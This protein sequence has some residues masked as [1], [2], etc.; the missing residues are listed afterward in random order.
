MAGCGVSVERPSGVL[1][2]VTVFIADYGRHASLVLPGD[3]VADAAALTDADVRVG[4]F[5]VSGGV[6]WEYSFGDWVFYAE[7]RDSLWNGGWALFAPTRGALGRRLLAAAET[8][9]EL[10]AAFDARLEHVHSIE[11]ERGAARRMLSVLHGRWADGLAY[12]ADLGVEPITNR[13]VNM[14]FVP[15]RRA[16]SLLNHCND[17][18]TAW[19]RGMGVETRGS[20]LVSRYVV[21]GAEAE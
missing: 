16:Y 13:S 10:R 5:D 11:V 9:S 1:D 19:L 8:E 17:E 6:M 15:D 18:L 21:V 20:S 3:V 2:P 12:A 14:R 7:D 4:S